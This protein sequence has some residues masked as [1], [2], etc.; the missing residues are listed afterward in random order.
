MPDPRK[1]LLISAEAT[2]FFKI[3]GLGDVGGTLPLALRALPKAPDV[4]LVL[5][6]HT[7]LNRTA[8]D[9]RPAAEFS[10]P[11]PDGGIPAQA[12]RVSVE[13]LPVYLIYGS[14][15][16]EHPAVYT[17][18]PA[19]DGHKFVFFSLAALE[20]ARAL[21]WQPDILHAQDWHTAPA[22]YALK[23]RPDE[24]FAKT[25]TLLTVHNLPYLGQG[26]EGAMASFGLPSSA[27]EALPV[28]ARYMP[29]PLG[30]S[31]ADKINTVS[32]GYA[33]EMLT[34]EF[35]SGLDE[36]LATRRAD[37]LG[38]LN[39]LDLESWNPETDPEIANFSAKTLKN[40]LENKRR[41]QAEVNIGVNSQ[42]PLISVVSRMDHQKG[43]DLVADALRSTM[44]RAWRAVILGTG[45]PEIEEQV[46]QLAREY[47]DRVRAVIRY[48]GALARRI[49]AG[50]DMIL[51][52]SRYEPCG[53]TQMIGMR[54]GCVPIARA[55]GGLR[56]TI[57]DPQDGDQP[58]GFLFSEAS[59]SDLADALH[60]ALDIYADKKA[61][62]QLQLSGLR[63][64]FSWQTSAQTYLDLYEQL[65]ESS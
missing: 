32:P 5:P 29:L 2:P 9:L 18:D 44:D 54:Y 7:P 60:R 27:D 51:I 30:L 59:A 8:Y 43:I 12:Y 41:L 50:S 56:D 4:R 23:A 16:A 61:W 57:T 55:T 34:P 1:V 36:F 62:R 35:G 33:A 49:Y 45:D 40:R 64:D 39:G 24:F 48:D 28:W 3:G 26:A 25:R 58:T 46:R 37:L 15:I 10:V 53:L 19:V 22:V 6:L 17:A 42:I 65:I 11:H 13:G 52:P 14:P 47:P 20:L 21:D 38:I 31:A 63:Q